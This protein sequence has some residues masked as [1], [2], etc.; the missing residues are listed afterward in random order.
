[1]KD[2]ILKNKFLVI[3]LL[4]FSV[5]C[6]YTFYQYTFDYIYGDLPKIITPSESYSHVLK[7]PLGINA[8]IDDVQYPGPNRFTYHAFSYV[9]FRIL[10]SVLRV[11]MSPIDSVYWSMHLLKF[12]TYLLMVGILFLYVR[13]FSKRDQVF[14][15][16]AVLVSIFP[17]FFTTYNYY[18]APIL[19]FTIAYTIAYA[20]FMALFLLFLYPIIKSCYLKKDYL[21]SNFNYVVWFFFAFCLAFSGPLVAPC[22]LIAVSAY[23]GIQY[24]LYLLKGEKSLSDIKSL[25]ISRHGF[26]MLF[27]LLT[28]LYSFYL[29]TYNSEGS[30]DLGLLQ[31]YNK[32]IEGYSDYFF[33]PYGIYL[34]LTVVVFNLLLVILFSKGK[35]FNINLI[36]CI[37]VLLVIGYLF[38]LPLGGYRNYRPVV[39]R[40]DT[41][42]PI[43]LILIFIFSYSSTFLFKKISCP[44]KKLYKVFLLFIAVYFMW[45]D[46][47]PP[48]DNLCQKSALKIISEST[49]NCVS[50]EEDCLM[51]SWLKIKSCE[52]ST[53]QAKLFSVWSITDGEVLFYQKKQ[54]E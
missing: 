50:L 45:I 42:M 27:A 38:F 18:Y 35:F 14:D 28:S 51:F 20:F 32:A 43:M 3:V 31:R 26:L 30:S 40:R 24:F 16:S 23:F 25:F 49:I 2:F 9:Y 10:P 11:F 17:F 7:D 22:M 19:D 21:A 6:T 13:L 53:L 46:K 48:H 29:G 8:I 15:Y 36:V 37:S 5:E 33:S 52:E 4:L 41:A 1:M 54:N 39:I 12:I 44:F 47:L 34:I